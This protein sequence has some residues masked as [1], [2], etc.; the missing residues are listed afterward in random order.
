M[1]YAQFVNL[2]RRTSVIFVSQ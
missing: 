2:D 1:R